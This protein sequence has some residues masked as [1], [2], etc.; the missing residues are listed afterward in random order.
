MELRKV[1]RA[2][3]HATPLTHWQPP[4]LSLVMRAKYVGNRETHVVITCTTCGN[5]RRFLAREGY[6][7]VTDR[8]TLESE[9]GA[10]AE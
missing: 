6:T 1:Y 2:R 7:L 8:A 5:V 10:A 9:A 4:K 3:P